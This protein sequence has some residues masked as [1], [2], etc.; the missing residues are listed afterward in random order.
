VAPWLLLR[1]C[2]AELELGLLDVSFPEG[3]MLTL[4]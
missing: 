1:V 2:G 3:A 4:A